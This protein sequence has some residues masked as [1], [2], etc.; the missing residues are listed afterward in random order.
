VL[1]ADEPTGNLDSHTGER[2]SD[3]LFEL[4]K[5]RGTTWCWSPTTNAWPAL[6]RQIRLDAGR[7][8]TLWSL[9]NHAVIAPVRPRPAP[10][11]ARCAPANCACCSFALLVAVAASTAIGYFGARLNGA[12][13]CAP[14]N[15]WA[16]TWCCRAAAPPASNRSIAAPTGL[17]PCAGGGVHQC[18]RRRQ[19]HPAV[20]HQGRR[21]H[22]PIA[23]Q[24]QARRHLTPRKRRRRPK[25]G[26]AWVEA[27]LLAAL[28]LA[29]GDSIDVGMKTLR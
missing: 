6:P 21:R 28:G 22:L 27:R 1:F 5:E 2:I 13:N 18:G 10:V 7:L 12:M 29:I 14:A 25:P 15:S 20:E 19:R 24:V 16:P 23:R 4:N 3:L 9:M 26:E 17:A 8:V 11:A